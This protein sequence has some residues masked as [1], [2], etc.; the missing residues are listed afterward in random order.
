MIFYFLQ[1]KMIKKITY[2]ET[3]SVRHLVLRVGKPIETCFFEDDDSDSTVHFGYF[4]NEILVGVVSLFKNKNIIF[5]AT[6]PFQIRGMAVLENHRK[7]GIRELLIKKC[8]VYVT[9]NLGDLIWFNARVIAVK[10]YEKLGYTA[11]GNSFDISD[12]G[13]HFIMS[14]TV[15]R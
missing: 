2:L 10:F 1:I 7:N 15:C 13:K 6:N 11:I 5:D 4:E 14:K 8:E 12:I 9:E 3:F